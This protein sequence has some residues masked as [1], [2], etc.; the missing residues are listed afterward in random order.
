M[1]KG[2]AITKPTQRE[3]M[4]GLSLPAG[5]DPEDWDVFHNLV[6]TDELNRLVV[7]LI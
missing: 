7:S 1:E 6:T 2:F 3:Y 4:G 5:I